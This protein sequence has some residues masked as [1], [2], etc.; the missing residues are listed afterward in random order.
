M[1]KYCVICD[2]KIQCAMMNGKFKNTTEQVQKIVSPTTVIDPVVI[3]HNCYEINYMNKDKKEDAKV[4]G[5]YFR[6][7][8]SMKYMIYG[9]G[10]YPS[11]KNL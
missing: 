8:E 3:S 1:N 5:L 11:M 9:S 10:K 7:G 4:E 2:H 6:P